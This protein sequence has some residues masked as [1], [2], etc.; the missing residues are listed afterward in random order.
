[1]ISV[2]LASQ[3]VMV[4]ALELAK[5]IL[6]DLED[7]KIPVSGIALKAIRLAR[8]LNDQKNVE[9]LKDLSKF[10]DETEMDR[11]ESITKLNATPELIANPVTLTGTLTASIQYNEYY[12]L[13]SNISMSSRILFDKKLKIH[14]YVLEK[15]YE[16]KF[17][18]IVGDAFFRIRKTVDDR[19]SFF[20]PSATKRFVSA[21]NN[22]NSENNEDWSNA[23]HS[24]RRI[25]EDLADAV[26]PPLPDSRIKNVNGNK[27]KILLGKNN[28]INRLICFVEDNGATGCST[29]VTCAH[30]NL[31]KS[32]LESLSSA[33]NKGTHSDI[34]SQE[35]AD[36]Y[37]V[38]TY[39]LVGDILS[40]LDSR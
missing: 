34:V 24:C 11:Q 28:Y 31:M 22:L 35:E 8:I 9:S 38:Y 1:M 37:V 29:E 27:T 21:Y 14:E 12:I 6:K 23:V 7:N 33:A 18:D 10:I 26:F 15:Y 5:D 17:S 30:L 20:V 3:K 2:F 13:K 19:I 39:M 16:L 25:L 4:E 40:L 36:R 32:R